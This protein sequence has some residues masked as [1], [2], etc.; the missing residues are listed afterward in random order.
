MPQSREELLAKKRAYAARVRQQLTPEKRQML[1]AKS[2]EHYWRDVEE[3]RRKGREEARAKYRKNIEESRKRRREKARMEYAKN[4]KQVLERNRRSL[5]RRKLADP[6]GLKA[7]RRAY[8]A[9]WLAAN[10]DKRRSSV[11]S[12]YAKNRRAC[13]LRSAAWAKLRRSDDPMFRIKTSLRNR[14][15]SLLTEARTTPEDAE[16]RQIFLW[17]E[18]LRMRGVADWRAKGMSIDHVIPIS[19]FNLQNADAIKAA[20]N[21]RNLFPLL[22]SENSSKGNRIR[23]EDIRRNWALGNQFLNECRS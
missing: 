19:K 16:A 17:F 4:P 20:N 15:H 14:L 7:K 22:R 6:E 1:N 8:N 10:P 23:P 13:C 3:S 11:R 18:W 2:R 21:W 9:K 12:Y 5:A